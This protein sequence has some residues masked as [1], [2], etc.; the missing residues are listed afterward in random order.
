MY[1]ISPQISKVQKSKTTVHVHHHS[2]LKSYF[3]KNINMPKAYPSWLLL[4]FLSWRIPEHSSYDKK[5]CCC[6]ML[7]LQYQNPFADVVTKNT[8]T[9]MHCPNPEYI[10]S[11]LIGNII[12]NILYGS[13]CNIKK[14]K[15]INTKW[16]LMIACTT[17]LNISSP[18][19]NILN[20]GGKKKAHS[21]MLEP[22]IF[23]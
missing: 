14:L 1:C 17:R 9:I 2:S 6:T 16:A 3:Y 23:S 8:V 22:N 5:S 19:T 11:L 21:H 10:W 18:K 12:C 4:A 15:I 7:L 20:R 13:S